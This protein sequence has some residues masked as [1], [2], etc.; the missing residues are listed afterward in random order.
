MLV[1]SIVAPTWVRSPN[2]KTIAMRFTTS[3]ANRLYAF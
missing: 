3:A 2:F 1:A